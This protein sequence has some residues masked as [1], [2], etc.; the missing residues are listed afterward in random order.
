MMRF[1][2]IAVVETAAVVCLMKSRRF[3]GSIV[4]FD[5]A[6]LRSAINARR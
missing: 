2:E 5:T 3:I 4:G 6:V 1:E